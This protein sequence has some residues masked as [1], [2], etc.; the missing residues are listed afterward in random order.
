VL[1]GVSDLSVFE[2]ITSR[3]GGRL[4]LLPTLHAKVYQTE[5]RCLVG[6]ANLTGRA[7][8]WTSPPN[9][10]LLLEVSPSH[11]DV[12]ALV[13]EMVSAAFPATSELAES[14]R[15]AAAALAERE[16]SADRQITETPNI[17]VV[18]KTWL[19]SCSRADQLWVVYSQGPNLWKVLGSNVEAARA[20][21][22]ALGIPQD[23]SKGL[24]YQ[25]VAATL[26]MMPIIREID[27]HAKTGIADSEAMA[28]IES[29][30]PSAQDGLSIE[31]RWE[32][33]KGWLE[34]FFPDRYRRVAQGEVL[35]VGT[36]KIELP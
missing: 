18:P 36:T 30:I 17:D 27:H 32:I 5:S 2:R 9:L 15:Q 29:D 33:L 6:S 22:A 11:P 8:G 25:Y 3:T 28:R 24:F 13:T 26:R 23:L 14:I 35:I 16:S 12:T 1:A 19:P 4:L 31:A 7:L 20:D 10:E 34:Y 21:I